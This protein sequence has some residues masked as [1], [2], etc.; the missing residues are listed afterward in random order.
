MV[1]EN[2]LYFKLCERLPAVHVLCTLDLIEPVDA[3]ESDSVIWGLKFAWDLLENITT[4]RTPWDQD[5]AASFLKF[6]LCQIELDRR[7]AI[8]NRYDKVGEI[9]KDS[10]SDVWKPLREM[11]ENLL[12]HLTFEGIDTKNRE[13]IK[14]L[15]KVSKDSTTIDLDDLSSGEKINCADILSVG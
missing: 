9:S 12:P 4:T 3:K 8:A 15:W 6:G 2:Q 11:A 13:E 10:L 1:A 14:C 7:E 5:D